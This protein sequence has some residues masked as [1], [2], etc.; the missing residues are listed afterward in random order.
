MKIQQDRGRNGETFFEKDIQVMA[1]KMA[2]NH[3]KWTDFGMFD[4]RITDTWLIN[5]E[6]GA[7]MDDEDWNLSANDEYMLRAFANKEPEGENWIRFQASGFYGN[8]DGF[9]I[10]VYDE[11]GQITDM[12]QTWFQY[13]HVIHDSGCLDWHRAK[14]LN[15]E[16]GK[17]Q[18]SYELESAGLDD[19]LEEVWAQI[20][21]KN[22]VWYSEKVEQVLLKMKLIEKVVD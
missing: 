13:Q 4:E 21:N 10:R 5:Y 9:A 22:D 20:K 19:H 7:A 6:N 18:L 2:G 15:D 17:R 8:L 11:N 12:F 1:K 16:S 14:Q 3:L